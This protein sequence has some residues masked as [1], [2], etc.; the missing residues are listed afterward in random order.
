MLRAIAS[1]AG[2]DDERW[3]EALTTASRRLEAEGEPLAVGFGL[4]ASALLARIHGRVDEAQRLAQ[5]AH[6]LSTRIG[7]WY[8]RVYASTQLARGALESDDWRGTQ[9]YAVESLQAAQ[10]LRNLNA[11]G[12]A[13]ELWAT[14]ELHEGRIEQAGRLFG[15]AQRCYRQVG[16]GPWRTDA[17]LHEQL[18]TDL[19]AALGERYEQLLAEARD[20]DLD[21]AIIQLTRSQPPGAPPN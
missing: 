8:V 19:K 14:A 17:E 4:V 10:R 2:P 21:E 7:E 15:L 12:Y 16:S 18:T 5:E 13:L 3:E 11:A 9:R 20:V 6:D 1:G